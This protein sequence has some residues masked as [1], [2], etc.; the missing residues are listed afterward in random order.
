MPDEGVWVSGEAGGASLPLSA[1]RLEFG[2]GR[3]W[4]YVAG[5]GRPGSR[6]V[7]FFGG[8]QGV[9]Q[10]GVFATS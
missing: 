8:A 9:A 5:R 3:T 1:N 7:T 6:G 2:C 10:S 4:R